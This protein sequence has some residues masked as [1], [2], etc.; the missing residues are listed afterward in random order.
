MA[1]VRYKWATKECRSAAP[2]SRSLGIAGFLALSE[3]LILLV[4]FVWAGR[5]TFEVAVYSFWY[6]P[7]LYVVT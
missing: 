7:L 3:I 6:S 1:P 5:W 2:F 4:N